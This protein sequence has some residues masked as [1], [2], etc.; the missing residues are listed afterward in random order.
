MMIQGVTNPMTDITLVVLS[1]PF[2][3]SIV[4]IIII[5][6]VILIFRYVKLYMQFVYPNAKYEAIGNRFLSEK[7]LSSLSESKNL[8]NLRENLN[9]YR[10]YKLAGDDVRS[11]QNSLDEH[12]IQTI[13]MMKNDSPRGIRGFY[14]LYI[15]RLHLPFIKNTVKMIITGRREE[16]NRDIVNYVSH[17]KTRV[18]LMSLFN[19]SNK[20]EVGA[21]LKQYGYDEDIIK[22]ITSS[23]KPD[24]LTVDTAFDRYILRRLKE[25][26]IP[27]RCMDAKQDL[28]NLL[29]DVLMIKG[30]LRAKNLGY[31]Y[32]RCLQ[33][34]LGAGNE[35]QPWRFQEMIKT[36]T[37]TEV[38]EALDGTSYYN[39]LESYMEDYKKD[40]SLQV[41]E[42]ALD[43]HLLRGISDVSLRYYQTM[44]PLLRFLVS[45]EFEVHNLKVIV[46]TI[47]DD[48]PYDKSKVLLVTEGGG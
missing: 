19:T 7:E 45:K 23:D 8:N 17:D 34:N 30:V 42:S 2:I 24:L 3:V 47:G 36:S 6:L 33:L 21:V 43:R 13:E 38:I 15:E 40:G 14:D 35:I 39:T 32:S 12:L 25:L 22:T 1:V 4:V 44:G 5:V 27:G 16:L 11:L 28:I 10:D 46:K 29:S 26:K 20:E 48:L 9:A 31:D 37:L 41:L 18:V